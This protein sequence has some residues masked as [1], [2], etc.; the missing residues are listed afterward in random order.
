MNASVVVAGDPKQLDAVTRSKRAIDLGFK[1]SFLEHL[2][3]RKLYRRD[4]NTD[5][6]NENYIAQLLKNYRSHPLILNISNSFFYDSKLQAKA[7]I[8][9][10]SFV[11]RIRM[12][13]F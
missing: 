3:D 2:C 6:Y 1:T 7:A 13:N 8:G 12:Y 5:K 11:S 4:P 9:M 10:F